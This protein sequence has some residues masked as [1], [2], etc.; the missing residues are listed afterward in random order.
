M[1]QAKKHIPV[2]PVRSEPNQTSLERVRAV[3]APRVMETVPGRLDLIWRSWKD[4]R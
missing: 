4:T 3:T 2:A 1:V